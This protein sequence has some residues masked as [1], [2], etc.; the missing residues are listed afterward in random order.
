MTDKTIWVLADD[1]AGN[2]AQAL[3]VAEAFVKNPEI[4]KV[5]YTRSV[6]LP[7][8]VRGAS[9]LGVTAETVAGL[10]EPFPDIAVAAG[11][12]AAPL[13]RYIKKKSGGK[14]K[15]VQIMYPG[16]FSLS[17]FDLIVLPRHDGC[18]LIRPNIMRVTGAPHR[19][20]PERLSIEKEKWTPVFESLPSPRIALIVG[21][22]TKDK[23]FTTDM[24]V[25]LAE[26][27]KALAEKLGGGSFL[28][29]TSRRTGAEQEK[30]IR[31][32]LPEPEFFYGWG[33]KEME[34]P[35]FGFLA[36]AD[37]IIVTGDSVSMCSEACAADAPVYIY[38]PQGTVGKK[39]ALLHRELYDD[40]YAVELTKNP[41][42]VGQRGHKRLN[43][44]GEIAA[45]IKKW[46]D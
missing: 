42:P 37:H 18:K 25:D 29:T 8:V 30:I 21:G 19:I 33:N 28:V 9:T 16:C 39:H 4:K 43:V 10:T 12:R 20:T 36:L 1:R 27:A 14:T 24:A 40:G 46:G 44:A 34:N 7:N 5:R 45:R 23:P 35:Y 31:D 38:A 26:R 32:A 15:I 17:D 13:L 11:R 3:G 2:T 6:V 22:A 41:E